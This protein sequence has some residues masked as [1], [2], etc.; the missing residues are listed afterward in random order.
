M[1]EQFVS[2]DVALK[3]KELGFDEKCFAYF[4]E[5]KRL[6]QFP[7]LNVFW[8]SNKEISFNRGLR[9]LLNKNKADLTMCLAPLWQQ[10][11]DWLREKHEIFIAINYWGKRNVTPNNSVLYPNKYN[12]T[13]CQELT[14]KEKWIEAWYGNYNEAREQAILKALELIK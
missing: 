7:D 6:S 13:I 11:I 5:H 4:N 1:K 2:Y 10:A 14:P 8:N 3:L 9:Y 12:Y